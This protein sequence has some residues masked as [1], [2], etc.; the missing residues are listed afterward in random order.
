[1]WDLIVSVPDRC[2]SFDY[3]NTRSV[4]DYFNLIISFEYSRVGG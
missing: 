1:M 3:P 4:Q 2:L